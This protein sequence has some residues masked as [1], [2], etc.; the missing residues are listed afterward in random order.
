[1]FADESV[2]R[3]PP[4]GVELETLLA[5]MQPIADVVLV[6]SFHDAALPSVLIHRDN[7]LLRLLD[8]GVCSRWSAIKAASETCRNTRQTMSQV[9]PTSSC[10]GATARSCVCQ[11]NGHR[12]CPERLTPTVGTMRAMRLGILDQSPI[13]AGGTARE[14]VLAT[15]ELAK[16]ADRL[17]YSRYWLAE[18]HNSGTLASAS[19]EILIPML[20]ENTE[21]IRVGSGGVMLT[22]YSAL[23]VAEVFRM[24]ETLFP[25]RIDMGLGRA[26]GSDGLTASALSHGP[27]ALPLEAYPDQIADVMGFMTG[28]LPEG[29]PY[30]T[31]R[32]APRGDGVPVPW[33]LG[34]AYDSARFAA[35]MGLGFSFAHFISPQ[36][37]ERVV[38]DYRERF[39][40]S[41]WLA[42]PMVIVG[43][44]AICAETDEQARRI[45]MSRHLMR[46]RREQGRAL[47]GVPSI[48]D[49]EAVELSEPE[50]EYIDFQHTLALEGSPARVREGLTTVAEQY[51]TDELLVVTITHDYA[52]RARSYELLARELELS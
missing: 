12:T 26:P 41:P 19:P 28:E 24:L 50:Q 14:A 38:A 2:I 22:H 33:L 4:D 47:G 52:D 1:M 25:G 48:E 36:G 13:R 42:E 21:R 9:S 11:V 7:A 18:H 5:M 3:L 15:I 16:L 44:A 6:E 29:H 34:S 32:A 37:G 31:L 43:V 23:K 49:A 46:L 20:A 40:P 10:G 17:G 27:G 8:A 30:A 45:A 35:E 39:Q 51:D